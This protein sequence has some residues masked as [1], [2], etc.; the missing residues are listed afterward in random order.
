MLCNHQYCEYE[1]VYVWLCC[2]WHTAKSSV[3]SVFC[4]SWIFA[5][6]ISY[7]SVLIQIAG[8]LS[9]IKCTHNCVQNTYTHRGREIG[10]QNVQ[11]AAHQAT[12]Q[13]KANEKQNQQQN[14]FAPYNEYYTRLLCP[15]RTR[16]QLSSLIDFPCKTFTRRCI[17]GWVEQFDLCTH[18]SHWNIK[19]AISI[20]D[21][22]CLGW[23]FAGAAATAAEC[24]HCPRLRASHSIPM[25]STETIVSNSPA[26]A[27]SLFAV[28]VLSPGFLSIVVTDF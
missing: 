28:R 16:Q 17:D 11:I 19:S 27:F 4:H 1:C 3:T 10:K 7:F 24:K 14:V 18:T 8:W 2:N 22:D 23:L 6:L 12:G 25:H 9:P 20:I 5:R 15:V 21:Y 26:I 13:N